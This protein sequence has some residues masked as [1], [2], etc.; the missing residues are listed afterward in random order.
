MP[1][2]MPIKA[3]P[4]SFTHLTLATPR[5]LLR[6][7]QASDAPAL[8]ALHSDAELMRHW[9]TPPWTDSA[10]ADRLIADSAADLAAGQ[11]MRLGLQRRDDGRLVG[12]CSLFALQRTS[13]RAEIGYLLARDSQGTGLMHEALQALIAWSFN[14]LDLN[15]LEADIDPRNRASAHVL[16]RLGFQLEGAL[17]ERWIVAGEVSDSALYGLLRRN[18]AA[19]PAEAA[20]PGLQHR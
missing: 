9:S 2:P 19:G 14:V 3:P 6:P 4:A 15:R 10:Q 7:L 12:T 18:W 13:R 17:R 11:A 20:A 1:M 16:G 8:F 5:L